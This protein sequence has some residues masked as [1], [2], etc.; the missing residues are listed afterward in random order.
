M[1]IA[2]LV[3]QSWVCR[4]ESEAVYSRPLTQTVLA[5]QAE[6]RNDGESYKILS[7]SNINLLTFT[8]FNGQV[9]GQATIRNCTFIGDYQSGSLTIQLEATHPIGVYRLEKSGETVQC[10]NVYELG[11]PNV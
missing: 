4:K 8:Y 7:P 3:V 6:T 10:F 2:S 11:K 1:T 9:L 5:F